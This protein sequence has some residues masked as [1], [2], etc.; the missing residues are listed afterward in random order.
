S[1]TRPSSGSRANALAFL[2][3]FSRNEEDQ[4]A[5]ITRGKY[6]K[7]HGAKQGNLAQTLARPLCHAEVTRSILPLPNRSQILREHAQN[8]RLGSADAPPRRRPR[9][10]AQ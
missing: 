7:I 3:E 10:R 1:I 9:N 4:K 8:D 5:R 2:N 6:S